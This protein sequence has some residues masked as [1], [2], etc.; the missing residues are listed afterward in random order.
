M[1]I[2]DFRV[3]PPRAMGNEIE[4]F[5]QTSKPRAVTCT[6]HI[7]NAVELL[8]IKKG[9]FTAIVDGIEYPLQQ[10][11]LILFPSN[12]VHYVFSQSDEENAYYVIKVPPTAYLNFTK[13]NEG[14]A[15]MLRL[16]LG[17]SGQ[18]L[19]YRRQELEGSDVPRLLRSM[20][21]ELET[22]AFAHELT[23][24]LKAMELLLLLLREGDTGSMPQLSS[25]ATELIYRVIVY[26]RAHY[27]QD[28]SETELAHS[29]GMS[30][31]YFSRTFKEVTG[32][33]FKK[34]LNKL[35]ID[36]AQKMLAKGGRNI[37]EIAADCGFNSISYFI[38]TYRSIV[39]ITPYKHLQQLKAQL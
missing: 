20:I 13:M 11:D 36:H 30:Y 5:L 22:S 8:F 10:G 26:V 12:A 21:D 23:V 14:A 39:G 9:S 4:F 34:Y 18:K 25:S 19:L 1:N 38:S 2:T 24:K 35:R 6:A 31:S 17:R 15:Y 27:A 29:M 3:E 28:I 33:T 7:H 16:S 32:M 37:S